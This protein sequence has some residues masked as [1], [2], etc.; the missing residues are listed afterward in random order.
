MDPRIRPAKLFVPFPR[1]ALVRSI[2]ARFADQVARHGSRS[3]IWTRETS[4]TY[5]ELDLASSRVADA[6][7]ETLGAAPRPVAI[8]LAQGAPL[9]IAILGVLKA[10]KP[11]VPLDPRSAHSRLVTVLGHARPGLCLLDREH[12][13]FGPTIDGLGVRS[14]EVESIATPR[15]APAPRVEIP[16]EATAY[17]YY[18]SGSTGEPKGVFDTH[19]NV[20]H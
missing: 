17:I 8:L 15:P 18:T 11:Y 12:A 10:G 16:A 7:L 14:M 13:A 2:P 6:L 20:L 5:E 1:S 4:L 19:R 3:A 9:V